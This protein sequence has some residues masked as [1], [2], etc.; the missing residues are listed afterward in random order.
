MRVCACLHDVNGSSFSPDEMQPVFESAAEL[1]G[2]LASP[3]RLRILRVLCEAEQSVSDIVEETGASQSN[4]SQHL[5][6][7]Y[8]HRVVARR[9]EGNQIHY[10]VS[11]EVVIE[12]CRAVC[13]QFAIEQLVAADLTPARELRGRGSSAR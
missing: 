12:L 4:V 2:L 5:A 9:R 11:N 10:R 6:L 3:M 13:T 7:L 1:F 8:R